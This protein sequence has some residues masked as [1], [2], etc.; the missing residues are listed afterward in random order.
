MFYT[1]V[2]VFCVCVPKWGPSMQECVP[3]WGVGGWD[4]FQRQYFLV[5]IHSVPAVHQCGQPRTGAQSILICQ[6]VTCSGHEGKM[7]VG[8]VWMERERWHPPV[9]AG[10]PSCVDTHQCMHT[11]TH[12]STCTK[13]PHKACQSVNQSVSTW[14][15][16]LLPFISP[17]T[18]QHSSVSCTT[19]HW[20]C[21]TSSSYSTT[22][23]SW[24]HGSWMV[25]M[26]VR[27]PLNL[28]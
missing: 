19:G 24:P 11:H 14:G 8:K 26:R 23:S 1:C 9:N 2:D 13:N 22:A 18:S 5:L 10:V 12:T 3:M 16:Q 28:D 15:T 17:Q 6:D 25:R 27:W 7:G 4:L 20:Q 21:S